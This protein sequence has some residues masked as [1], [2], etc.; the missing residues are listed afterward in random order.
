[1]KKKLILLDI[2]GTVFDNNKRCIHPSTITAIKEAK[3]KGHEIVIATGRAY[4]ML[5]SISEIMPLIDHFVLINGQHV[6]SNNDVIYEDTIKV[7][8]MEEITSELKN[9]NITYGF[10]SAYAEAISDIN[11]DIKSTFMEMNLNLPPRNSSFYTEEKVY[12]MWCFCSLEEADVLRG[13]FPSFEFIKWM[14]AG[15]DIIKKGQSKGKGLI[16]LA[17]HL[18]FDLE[19]TISI[20]DGDNDIELSKTAGIGIA[21]GNATNALKAASDYITDDIDKDGIYNALKHF[22][23]I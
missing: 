23:I 10:Q 17:K 7:E 12:Q 9:M 11:D 15:Y 16:K 20:G 4:F 8:T 1:M 18:R 6:I 13:K 2:D 19:D 22:E 5:Y 21:M 14:S 3:A